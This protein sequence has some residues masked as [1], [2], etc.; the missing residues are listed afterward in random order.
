MMNKCLQRPCQG[1]AFIPGFKDFRVDDSG[2]FSY[3]AKNN[4]RRSGIVHSSTAFIGCSHAQCC[5]CYGPKGGTDNYCLNNCTSI[6]GG[7]VIK[8]VY[9]WV[10]IR[11]S[12]PK[13]LW[14][15][16]I[17][18][19]V[20]DSQGNE[21][22]YRLD[23]ETGVKEK[24]NCATMQ[25]I[26]KNGAV[27]VVPDTKRLKKI[28]RA[29]GLL[30]FLPKS[31]KLQIQS[32][33]ELETIAMKSEVTEAEK[34]FFQKLTKE[35]QKQ[36]LINKN[37]R[38]KQKKIEQKLVNLEAKTV[39]K[40]KALE[41]QQKSSKKILEGKIKKVDKQQNISESNLKSTIQRLTRRI[42]TLENKKMNEIDSIILRGKT[43]YKNLL[44][45]WVPFSQSWTLCYRASRDG[46]RSRTFHSRCDNKGPTVTIIRYNSYIFGGYTDALWGGIVT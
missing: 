35:Q 29:P 38:K 6:N 34:T 37:F 22:S 23:E 33:H 3:S 18:Y 20:K 21:E 31:K 4:T 14:R 1:F 19:T 17:D 11:S 28:P 2:S 9:T 30:V 5:A 10:W 36:T 40:Q 32:Q 41:K 42:Q 45:K 26:K 7:K 8:E 13:R 43:T 46:W 12:L 25:E 44:S 24:G 15:K 27:L 16:C 39:N